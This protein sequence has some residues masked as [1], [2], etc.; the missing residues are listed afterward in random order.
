MSA[1]RLNQFRRGEPFELT[2]NDRT[3][4]AYSGESLATILLAAGVRTFQKSLDGKNRNR[5]Y[6]GMG[7]CM[8]CLVTVDGI[9]SCQACKTLARPGMR[10]ETQP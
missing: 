8:Q 10:V 5:L 9:P 7:E 3:V 6:C 1:V 2:V 4:T